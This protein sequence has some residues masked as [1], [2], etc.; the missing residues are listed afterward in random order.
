MVVDDS[1]DNREL[2]ATVLRDAGFVVTTAADGIEAL[3]IAAREKP[4]VILMDLAMPRLD[5]FDTIERLRLE[6]HGRAAAI[7]VVSAFNDRLSKTRA[8]EL[9]A[10]A[11]L[12]KPCTPQDL[13][14]EVEEAF[15]SRL[16][17]KAAAG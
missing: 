6:E 16:S 14:D 15:A 17:P 3:E 5:G 13:V 4:D 1:E 11:F 2:F 8:L 10:D 7:I 9:G 12:P